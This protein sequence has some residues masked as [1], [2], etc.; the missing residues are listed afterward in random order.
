MNALLRDLDTILCL[1]LYIC[2]ISSYKQDLDARNHS[3]VN[4]A[5]VLYLF[6]N[7]AKIRDCHSLTK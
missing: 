3:Y 2:A 6:T 5:E 7:N 1:K 4:K